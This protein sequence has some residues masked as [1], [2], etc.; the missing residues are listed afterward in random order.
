MTASRRHHVV[1]VGAGVAGLAAAHYL[2]RPKAPGGAGA[3]AGAADVRVTVLEGSPRIGGK[4]LVSE[5]AGI[6]VDAGAEAML[7]RRPEGLGLVRDLG[8]A[9]DLVHPGTT[10]ASIWSYGALRPL[11]GGHVMGVPADLPELAR[12]HILSGAGLTRAPLDLVLPATPRGADVSVAAYVGARLGREVVDRLVEPLLGGVY[13]GLAD[14]LSFDATMPALAESARSHRSLIAAARTLRRTAPADAGPVFTTLDGGLGTL[15]ELLAAAVRARGGTIRTDAMVRGLHRRGAGQD[16]GGAAGAN[17]AGGAD[18]AGGPGGSADAGGGWRLTV[19]PARAPEYIDADAVILA[20]PARPAARLL[21]DEA[22][23]AARELDAIEYASMA[24]VTLAYTANA[25]TRPLRGSGY[26]VPAVE[27]GDTGVKAVTYSTV[28]WPHLTREAPGVV[29]VRCSIGRYG[30]EHVLQRSD[31]D[32]KA[33]AITE[34]ART[35]GASELPIDS[36]VTRWGGGLPQYTVGHADRVARIR[37][38]VAGLPNLAVCG[39]AYDGLGVPAC[40]ATARAAAT[41]VLD[42]L[43]GRAESKYGYDDGEAEGTTPQQRDPIHDVV[44]LPGEE[45]RPD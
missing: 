31:G 33:A 28:K 26:L 10:S 6:Q 19:G 29:I 24:I 2:T 11:P 8:H 18:G 41:R 39:A 35:S 4:L 17:G 20:V 14:E 16:A 32:L 5:V 37:S 42:G 15:P 13:A 21:A 22:P 12:S 44:G 30:D 3:R 1:V 23:P 40:V 34:M 9:D 36:R 43:I 7:A 45:P 27:V 25:F 38:A